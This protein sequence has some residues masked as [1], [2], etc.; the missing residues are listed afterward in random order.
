MPSAS[1]RTFGPCW[2]SCASR[3]SAD[4]LDD[5]GAHGVDGRL[6]PVVDL[7]LHQDVRDVILD[8]LRADVELAGDHRVV[9]AVCDQLENLD[10]A[11]GQ[12]R[13]DRALDLRLSA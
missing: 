5:S 11:L 10:L 3:P 4:V 6:D 7:K 13:P 1:W 2:P 9:L 12:L 8:R